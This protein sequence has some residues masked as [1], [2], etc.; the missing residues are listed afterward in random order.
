MKVRDKLVYCPCGG[1]GVHAIGFGGVRVIFKRREDYAQVD[2][3]GNEIVHKEIPTEDK[4]EVIDMEEPKLTEKQEFDELMLV[5]GHQIEVMENLSQS[6][7]FSPSTN[8]DLLTHFA[9]LQA[10]FRWKMRQT[11]GVI[12]VLEAHA[13]RLV[14]LEDR[15]LQPVVAAR[16]SA[17]QRKNPSKRKA[18]Q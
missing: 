17:P 8:Q 4:P 2:D 1:V 5:L 7:R 10:A 3:E 13:S 14:R 18:A 11:D 6:G 9:W 15:L 12:R 16:A